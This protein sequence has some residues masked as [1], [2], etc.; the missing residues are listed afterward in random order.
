MSFR[1]LGFGDRALRERGADLGVLGEATFLLLR[2]D[3]LAVD[4]YVV[5]ALRT[6]F[7]LRFMLRLGVQL[8]RETR[9]PCVVAVSDG[10]VLDQDLGH[11]RKPIGSATAVGARPLLRR[12][13]RPRN[14][15]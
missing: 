2:E 11:G 12:G 7:D 9:G 10:A 8:G 13:H 3:Q 4:E 15:S 1:A 5:L 6:L 14:G